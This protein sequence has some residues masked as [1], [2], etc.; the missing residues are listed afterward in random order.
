MGQTDGAQAIGVS[1]VPQGG[2]LCRRYAKRHPG[3]R[4]RL[5]MPKALL[6]NFWLLLITRFRSNPKT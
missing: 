1:F 2:R 3:P 6:M 5:E 4:A